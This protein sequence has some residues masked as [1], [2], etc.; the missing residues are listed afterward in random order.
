MSD[1]A[2]I[3]VVGMA[4]WNRWHQGHT[5]PSDK[6]R[7]PT[8]SLPRTERKTATIRGIHSASHDL[9]LDDLTEYERKLKCEEILNTFGSRWIERGDELVHSCI[10][11][12]HADRRPSASLNW[13]KLTYNCF[14]CGVG[15][16]IIELLTTVS[17]VSK[18]EAFAYIMKGVTASGVYREPTIEPQSRH[19]QEELYPFLGPPHPYLLGRGISVENIVEHVL[20]YDSTSDRIVI[21][22]FSEGYLLGWQYRQ[23]DDT[24]EPKYEFTCG[25]KK[26]RVLYN[27]DGI[28]WQHE[29]VVVVEGTLDVVSQSHLE[30]YHFVSTFGAEVSKDQLA[31]LTDAPYVILFFDNDDAGHKA[32]YKV[33]DYLSTH[34]VNVSVVS[35]PFDADPADLDD[36][37]VL[38]LLEDPPY[39]E[40]WSP[41]SSLVPALCG[42]LGGSSGTRSGN[43]SGT[44]DDVH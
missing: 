23:T 21:P 9:S 16:G 41:P 11:G 43:R 32:T 25:L 36:E 44:F 35:N 8:P 42:S 20:G 10:L 2:D 13:R 17:K 28:D 22:I 5:T 30:G 34:G 15:M 27:W 33:G 7:Q 19:H 18:G 12:E 4:E 37:T 24:R 39:F 3:S 14:S 29:T 38:D 6:G 31:I 1:Y 26:G 40:E